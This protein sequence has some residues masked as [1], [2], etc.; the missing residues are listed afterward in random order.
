HFGSLT[1]LSNNA[2]LGDVNGDGLVT[3]ADAMLA[4][5]CWM[6]GVCAT[7]TNPLAANVC[8]PATTGIT[9][10]DAQAIFDVY[11]GIVPAC[12]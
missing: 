1:V 4:F 8:D 9:P 6:N 10:A 2:L 5:E 7:G 12:F 3:P 11:L